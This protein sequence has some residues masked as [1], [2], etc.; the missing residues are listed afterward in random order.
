MNKMGFSN[1]DGIK[2]VMRCMT[3]VRYVVRISGELFQP[4]VPKGFLRQEDPISRTY[5]FYVLRGYLA[6]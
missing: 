5:L 6:Y 2:C 3:K 4:F 1:D